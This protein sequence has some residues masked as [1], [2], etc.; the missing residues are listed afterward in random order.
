MQDK[1]DIATKKQS[2]FHK[3]AG[4]SVNNYYLVSNKKICEL[5]KL[6]HSH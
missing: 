2:G 3:F 1:L 5:L 6:Q 4:G